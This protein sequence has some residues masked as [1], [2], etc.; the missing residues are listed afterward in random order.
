[1][2][3]NKIKP[4]QAELLAQAKKKADSIA[5]KPT[6]DST[7]YYTNKSNKLFKQSTDLLN[8]P[9]PLQPS[10]DNI[11][12]RSKKANQLSTAAIK[13]QN[14]ALRQSRKGK[15]GYDKNGFPVAT[16]PSKGVM[17]KM[18]QSTTNIKSKN[19]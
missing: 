5:T 16:K 17:G 4:S 18:L 8:K 13:A 14:D 3:T 6:A 11:T 9:Y 15:P 19:K 7:D 2:R 10:N 1:M 12:T